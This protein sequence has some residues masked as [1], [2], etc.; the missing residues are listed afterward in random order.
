MAPFKHFLLALLATGSA[1]AAPAAQD[2]DIAH[3]R[4]GHPGGPPHNPSVCH[5]RKDRLRKSWHTLTNAQKKAY[6]N[7]ELCLMSKPSTSGLRGAR[8]MF[9]DFQSAHVSMTEI[10]HYAG[11]FLP[12]HRLF[13]WAHEQALERECGYKG[14]QP[15]W[16]EAFDAG[17]FTTSVLH[18]RPPRSRLWLRR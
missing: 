18:Q 4:P 10:V 5:P 2:A 1:A 11:Q 13:V 15:Y 7:A 16:D 14:G 9:D 17:S 12:Y 6:I 8:T 3:H